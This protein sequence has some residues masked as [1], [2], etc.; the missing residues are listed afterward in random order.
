[1]CEE[2]QRT[3]PA[4][5]HSP[6]LPQYAR[7]G[8]GQR[9]RGRAIRHLAPD[10]SLG[11]LGGCPYRRARAGNIASEDAIHNVA[12][13]GYRHG[14]GSR[15]IARVARDLPAIVGHDVP[16]Q[17][18]KAGPISHC[19]RRPA[20]PLDPGS[21]MRAAFYTRQGP[22]SEVFTVDEQPTPQPGPGEVRV[23]VKLS[24][25]NPSDWKTRKGGAGAS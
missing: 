18:S 21:F 23:R 7:H 25:V 10:G 12:V 14:R 9:A 3:L 16:A 8:P 6:A 5:L 4:S 19:M 24:G 11:G 1:M 17:V 22:A 15:S 20:S 2:L 13:M